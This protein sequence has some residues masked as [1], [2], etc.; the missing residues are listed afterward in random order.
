M[1]EVHLQTNMAVALCGVVRLLGH[2]DH[3]APSL[4]QDYRG[5]SLI[6]KRPPP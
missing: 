3:K 5:T 1:G 2:L 4:P 6:R